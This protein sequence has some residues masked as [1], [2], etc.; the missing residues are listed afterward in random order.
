[1]KMRCLLL[2]MLTL[3]SGACVPFVQH[4][5]WV[6]EGTSGGGIVAGNVVSGDVINDE[7]SRGDAGLSMGVDVS[8]RQG[9]VLADSSAPAFALGLTLPAWTLLLTAES[10]TVQGFAEFLAL[11]GYVSVPAF[12][13]RSTALGIT[14]SRHHAMPYVQF[15]SGPSSK[16]TWY[17]THAVLLVPSDHLVMWM[18]S[19]TVVDW[20]KQRPR[21]THYNFGGAVGRSAGSSVYMLSVGVTMEL[22]GA[23]KRVR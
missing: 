9:F 7:G 4:G 5:P 2:V 3:M 14:A 8:L 11:D 16:H 15:G 21:A 19:F 10:A 1:M 17:V 12:T 20:D 22:F 13:N 6:H 23:N 18:P